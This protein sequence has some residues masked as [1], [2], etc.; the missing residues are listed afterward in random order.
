MS[1]EAPIV[2]IGGGLSAIMAALTLKEH[3]Y[4]DILMVEK[5][6][7]VGGR[8]A[9][10]RIE[11]GKVDHG[12]QFFTV[13]TDRFQA[14]VDDWLKRDLVK[15]WFGD[16]Y[17]RYCSVDGMN[18][19][20]KKLAEDIPVRLQT[21]IIEMK[22]DSN[23][24]ILLTDQ[25]ESINARAVIVTAPAPQAKALLESDEL[26]VNA[27]VLEK[28]DE[29]VFNP[30]LVG[31]FHFHQSTNLPQNGHL[32]TDLPGGVMRLVDHDKKGMS[33]LTTVSVYMTGEWS[34]AHYDLEDEEVLV[35]MKQITSQY[36]D[37]DSIISS[38]LKKWR[39]AEAVQFLRQPFLN[40]NLEYP[41]L[42][43][44]DAFLHSEDT[45]GR[46]RLES[47]FLSGIAVGE[48]LVGLLN[49]G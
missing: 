28:L 33:P 20:A 16:Q 35:K 26:Q 39:Y 48:E 42:V 27:E 15:V 6:R 18:P 38:Q 41:V 2:I 5:S 4:K 3:G 10:R 49:K 7:S 21:R 25:G 23:G 12:A 14:F 32:D 8:M 17:P 44:G 31:L 29:I 43:A 30:C 19:F 36:F 46:T 24:Y 11:T 1:K 40:S 13:R 45:A 37:S 9:T 34:N 47:A 22:K